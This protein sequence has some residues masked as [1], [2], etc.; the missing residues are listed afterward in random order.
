[1]TD[2]EARISL[3]IQVHMVK[4]IWNLGCEKRIAG[5]KNEL[6]EW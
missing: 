4:K 1:M 3:A 6:L 2:S 5:L